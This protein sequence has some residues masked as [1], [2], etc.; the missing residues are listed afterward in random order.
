MINKIIAFIIALIVL[1][2][3]GEGGYILGINAGKRIGTQETL[4]N[5]NLKSQNK[6]EEKAV[7]VA[8]PIVGK[9]VA[10]W[11][12]QINSLPPTAIWSSN[13]KVSVGGQ[14]VAIDDQSITFEINGARKTLNLPS[15]ISKIEKV[16]YS[17]Y[18]HGDKKYIPESLTRDSL[19]PGDSIGI[20]LAID[21]LTG[22]TTFLEITKQYKNQQI[23]N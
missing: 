5:Q 22:K 7:S 12:E 15:P 11:V 2:L 13:W 8:I 19:K 4:K 20:N 9:S 17:Q 3:A 18:D 23:F 14:L 1:A 10:Q 21:T 16:W 6:T